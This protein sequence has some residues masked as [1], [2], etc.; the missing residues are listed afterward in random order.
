M[1]S[2][3]REKKLTLK[4]DPFLK[5]KREKK[6]HY[7]IVL[8]FSMNFENFIKNLKVFVSLILQIKKRKQTNKYL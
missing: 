7:F 1:L 5:R 6:N 8:K 2:F 4:I 3:E